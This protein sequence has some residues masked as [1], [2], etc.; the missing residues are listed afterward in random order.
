M[1]A[2]VNIDI[3]IQ[4]PEDSVNF[5]IPIDQTPS[6][7][8]DAG[9][10]E[11]SGAHDDGT[12]HLEGETDSNGQFIFGVFS[13]DEGQTDIGAWIDESEDDTFAP[14]EPSSSTSVFWGQGRPRKVKTRLTLRYR[15]GAFRGKV[16]SK[17]KGC[18][19]GRRVTVKRKKSGTDPSIGSDRSGS[20]GIWKVQASANGRYYAK[21]RS[22]LFAGQNRTIRCKT[23]RS[24][25]IRV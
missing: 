5:C 22:K 7:P 10:H 15:N 4:G 2:G 21:V 12:K 25:T 16:K 3:H 20:K 23:D 13:P 19:R 8:P 9:G 11:G 24:R 6:R 14:A 1:L 17:V 18:T